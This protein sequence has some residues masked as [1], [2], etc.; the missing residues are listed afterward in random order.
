MLPIAYPHPTGQAN[1]ITFRAAAALAAQGAWDASPTEIPIIAYDWL[2]LYFSYDEDADATDGAVDWYLE[3]SPYSIDQV[4]VQNWFQMT[5]YA[6]GVMAAG[7]DIQ[8]NIQREYITY[9]ATDAAIEAF[10]YGPL[11]LERTIERIRLVARE[12]G[13]TDNPGLFHV[14]G[15]ANGE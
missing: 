12:S 6:A 9:A 10:V 14:V 11:Q 15:V 4:G 7:S 8:S 1:P 3:Y 2:T 5:L 13:D